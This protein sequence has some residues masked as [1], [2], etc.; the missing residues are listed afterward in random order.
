MRTSEWKSVK[1]GDVITF[2]RGF[3]LPKGKR[4]K[5]TIPIISSSGTDGFHNESKV[6]G[7]GVVTGR[8]GTLG[9]V[10]FVEEDFWPLNTTLYV[11]D[12]KENDPKFVSYFLSTLNLANQNTAGAV[13]GL[14]RNALHLINVEVPVIGIQK[15]IASI[16]SS[17]DDLIENNKRRI[18]ILEHMAKLI[19]EE[20]FVKFRFPGHENVKMI[21]SELR[22][23]PE[24]WKICRVGS[25]LSSLESGSRPKGGVGDLGEGI[26][27]IGAEN[28][29]GLGIYDFSK[30]KYVSSEFFNKMKKGIVKHKDVLL[31]KDGAKIGRKTM[32]CDNFPH[33][34]C[35][36]N[37][38]VFI[39]RSKDQKCQNYLYFWLDLDFM[40]ENIK[41]LNSNAAQPG[42]NQ[43][44]VKSLPILIPPIEIIEEINKILEPIL[45][46]IFI[47]AKKNQNLRKTRDLLLPK[48]ISGE[49]DVS[50]LDIHIRNEFQE[51]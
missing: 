39:L 19:Y 49:I 46:Q 45:N 34:K 37:E 27:S 18:E 8:Y 7:P 14:N 33:G 47:L 1:L 41:N 38:H 2:Q 43:E 35:C 29:I 50:D 23:I 10:F 16:L 13:P 15:K 26:P 31:Y 32:F 36:I 6:K 30:E 44:D 3:D 12:F 21:S 42:I 9:K 11:R 24:G 22:E 48:L 40:T 17:Y 5:G 28:I 20:W 4:E 25:L 51:S